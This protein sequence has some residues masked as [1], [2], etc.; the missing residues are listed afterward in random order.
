MTIGLAYDKHRSGMLKR[1]KYDERQASMH[2]GS[3]RIQALKECDARVLTVRRLSASSP[4][5]LAI[6]SLNQNQCGA[7]P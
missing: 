4:T 5:A 3:V 6:D 2:L 1:A 7:R